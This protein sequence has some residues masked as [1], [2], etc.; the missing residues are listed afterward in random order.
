MSD[1]ILGSIVTSVFALTG[2]VVST[3]VSKHTDKVQLQQAILREYFSAR[4]NAF[5]AVYDSYSEFSQ[6]RDSLPKRVLLLHEINRA[7]LVA[8][9]DTAE[10]LSKFGAKIPIDWEDHEAEDLFHTARIAAFH[11]MEKDMIDFQIPT[12]KRKV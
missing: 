4:L 1:Y 12:I 6:D 11:A 5:N 2:V 9:S 10:L 8:S 3:F 7:C